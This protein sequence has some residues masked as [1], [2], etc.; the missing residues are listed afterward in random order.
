MVKNPNRR[1][2]Y[3]WRTSL[4]E[5][6]FESDTRAGKL[7]DELLIV[8]ILLSVIAV[9][10]DSVSMVRIKFG[11]ILFGWSGSSLFCL[12]LSIF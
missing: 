7:F 12:R 1:S 6:I 10:L 9:M 3:E 11:A 2:F 8:N 4:H 5:I